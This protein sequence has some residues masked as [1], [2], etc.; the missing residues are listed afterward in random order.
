[1]NFPLR[2]TPLL[3]AL[4]LGSG[5]VVEGTDVARAADLVEVRSEF[6]VNGTGTAGGQHHATVAIN[7]EG[8]F[9][10]TWQSDFS[11]DLSQEIG[12]RAFLSNGQSWSEEFLVN[13]STR[14]GSQHS[15]D[16]ANDGAAGWVVVWPSAE[17]HDLNKV[18]SKIYSSDGSSAPIKVQVDSFPHEPSPNINRPGV[19]MFANG[20][21]VVIWGTAD[22]QAREL[23]YFVRLFDRGGH[24]LTDPIQ[25][26]QAPSA[27]S[28]PGGHTGTPDIAVREIDGEMTVFAAW[29]RWREGEEYRAEIVCRKFNLHTMESGDEFL[30][31]PPAIG[32]HQGR[33]MVDINGRGDLLVVWQET[34]PADHRFDVH[35]LK[36]TAAEASWGYPL[37]PPGNADFSQLLAQGLLSE[38][39]GVVLVWSRAFPDPMKSDVFLM[40]YN[41]L[42]EPLLDQE[43]RVNKTVRWDQKRPA[44]AMN[45]EDGLASLAVIWESWGNDGSAMGVYGAVFEFDGFPEVRS[46]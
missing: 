26:N 5:M 15:P 3:A 6:L 16:V 10:V 8:V 46:D 29:K 33:P 27:L 14:F 38:S 21:S 11:S 22:L 37:D 31:S 4:L 39:G 20:D 2:S 17:D 1:M 12:A 40:M 18:Y 30:I 41:E 9:L 28:P 34:N 35:S 32:A 19:G 23:K 43:N 42:G 25:V 24:A 45:E 44:L 7:D 36:F 13:T